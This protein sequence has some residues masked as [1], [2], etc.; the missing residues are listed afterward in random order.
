MI[1]FV[2]YLIKNVKE[3]LGTFVEFEKL[4]DEMVEEKCFLTS[5]ETKF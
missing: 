3:I 1:I 2:Y 5:E 4:F